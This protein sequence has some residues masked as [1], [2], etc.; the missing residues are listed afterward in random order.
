M[1]E[2]PVVWTQDTQIT[3]ELIKIF[4][5]HNSIDSMYI[6]N[7]AFIIS[8]DETDPNSFNQVKGKN[9]K[10]YFTENELYKINV[11][12]NSETIYFVRE[13]DGSLIGINRAFSANMEIFVAD[14]Q[15]TDIFYFDKPDATLFPEEE[16][17]PNE[18]RLRDF[19]WHDAERPKTSEDIFLWDNK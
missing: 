1:Y 17:Q 18:L 13:E 11:L 15:I 7:S 16:I 12:G 14:R 5:S 19:K 9:M 8:M 6:F 10:A 4:T 2:R 3:S